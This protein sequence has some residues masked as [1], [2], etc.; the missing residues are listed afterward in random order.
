MYLSSQNLRIVAEFS[1][2]LSQRDSL[3][4]SPYSVYY[5]SPPYLL[6]LYTEIYLE[7]LKDRGLLHHNIQKIGNRII[8]LSIDV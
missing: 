2:I 5:N 4:I 8:N 6:L 3:G 1:E 7:N